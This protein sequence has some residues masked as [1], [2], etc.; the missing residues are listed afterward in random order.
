MKDLE[1]AFAKEN[2]LPIDFSLNEAGHP[3]IPLNLNNQRATFLLDTGATIN[4][5]DVDFAR[6]L[7]LP[8]TLTGETG[9]GAGGLIE[10]IY[11]LGSLELSHEDLTFSFDEFLAMSFDS[12]R[13][14][15]QLKGVKDD[16]QGI[17]GF[18]FFK[19]NKCFIDYAENRI[20]VKV[21]DIK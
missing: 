12:I 14:A 19:K 2:Y 10:E 11:K 1:K 18:D 8:L 9:G 6:K 3:T 5:L 17:L 16:F 21:K 7:S 15:L 4:V 13:Q 20:F